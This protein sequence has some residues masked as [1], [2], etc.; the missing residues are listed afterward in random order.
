MVFFIYIIF[1]TTYSIVSF[2]YIRSLEITIKD[3]NSQVS[4]LNTCVNMLKQ[5][6]ESTTNVVVNS[7]IF[8]DYHYYVFGALAIV[9]TIVGIL[10]LLNNK[11]FTLNHGFSASEERSRSELIENFVARQFQE[12]NVLLENI[13]I[14]I[15]EKIIHLSTQIK[16]N[17]TSL[18]S[19]LNSFS[20]EEMKM[21]EAAASLANSITTVPFPP[22]DR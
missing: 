21:F 11:N 20:E 14:S 5:N 3:L 9:G 7:P 17:D 15:E 4:N 22:L 2:F 18:N 10:F 1:Q 19:S 8:S 12:Q 16:L 13:R 6:E